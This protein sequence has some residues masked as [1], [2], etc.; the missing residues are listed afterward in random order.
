MPIGLARPD[1]TQS[2]NASRGTIDPSGPGSEKMV[3]R[4]W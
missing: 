1:T 4:W 2:G 3:E